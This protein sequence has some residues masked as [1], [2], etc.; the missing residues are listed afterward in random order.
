MADVQFRLLGDKIA[1]KVVPKELAGGFVLPS[2]VKQDKPK[3]GVVSQVGP[4]T[5]EVKMEVKI[6]DFIYFGGWSDP[7]KIGNDEYYI[8]SQ[9]DVKAIRA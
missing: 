1:V 5:D 2:N 4:G 6:G 8:I 3:E 9:D 7:A